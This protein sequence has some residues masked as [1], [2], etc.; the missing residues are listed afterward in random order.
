MAYVYNPFTFGLDYTD[1]RILAPLEANIANLVIKTSAN[2]VLSKSNQTKVNKLRNANTVIWPKVF[3]DH[4]TRI[5]TLENTDFADHD[6]RI[7]ALETSNT[8]LWEEVFDYQKP[9]FGIYGN[10]IEYVEDKTTEISRAGFRGQINVLQRDSSYATRPEWIIFE[11]YFT[12]NTNNEVAI[13]TTN[14]SVTLEDVFDTWSRF[15]FGDDGAFPYTADNSLTAFQFNPSP[16]NTISCL[17]NTTHDVGFISPEATDDYLLEV[18]VEVNGN[19]EQEWWNIQYGRPPGDTS[20]E[21]Y[22]N[23]RMGIVLAYAIDPVDPS[24]H[25]VMSVIRNQDDSHFTWFVVIHEITS[26]VTTVVGTE[27]GYKRDNWSNKA[28]FTVSNPARQTVGN[29]T[30]NGSH[31]VERDP[32]DVWAG[33]LSRASSGG[34]SIKVRR[35]GDNFK[36][37]TSPY[38]NF[39]I[40]NNTLIEFDLNMAS[41]G[42]IGDAAQL[43]LPVFD[44]IAQEGDIYGL[45]PTDSWE[46]RTTDVSKVQPSNRIGTLDMSILE[47][48]KGPKPYGFT[49]SSQTGTTFDVVQNE[50]YSATRAENFVFDLTEDKVWVPDMSTGTYKQATTSNLESELGRGRIIRDK[51]SNDVFYFNKDSQIVPLFRQGTIDHLTVQMETLMTL[52]ANTANQVANLYANIIHGTQ[53]Q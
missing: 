51:T 36:I 45:N 7:T 52:M 40:D 10:K 18:R 23:D 16:A 42:L 50:N 53:L 17:I 22:D 41:Y 28:L 46:A 5:A 43:A 21:F 11:G 47:H 38:N 49:C 27:P 24:I 12:A 33:A 48:F 31:L 6:P 30:I 13:I 14:L 9:M 34:T 26:V 29:L 25:R 32:A 1:R 2:E 44:H 4:E 19:D 37:W 3:V 15:A 35:Q 8:T 39:T 20:S